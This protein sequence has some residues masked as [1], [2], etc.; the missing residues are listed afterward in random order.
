MLNNKFYYNLYKNISNHKAKICVIGL[1]YVGLK[2]LLI[3]KK[4]FLT[5]GYDNNKNKISKIKKNLSPLSHI[6]DSEIK[7]KN[8]SQSIITNLKKISNFNI[9]IICLPTPLKNKKPDLSF[10]I[11]FMKEASPFLKE[12]QLLILEST[13]YPG[14]TNEII[15]PFIKNK[16]LIVGKNFFL[17]YSPERENP[18]S[19]LKFQ[20]VTKI[21]SGVTKNCQNLTIN[22]YK[23]VTKTVDASSV[24][25]AEFAKLYEN[26]YRSVN[27]GLV[28]EMKMLA[29]KMNI[30]IYEIIRLAKTKPFGFK[31]FYPGPGIGGHCIPVDPYYLSWKAKN[32]NF[33]TKFIDLSGKINELT[34]D[35]VYKE[36]MKIIS[37]N[38][39]K[40]NLSVLVIG[41]AYKKNID[42]Y[43]ESASIKIIN[44]LI[45]NNIRIDYHDS[46]VPKIILDKKFT[47]KS[48]DIN[49]NNIKKYTCVILL[50]DHDNINY[51]LILNN[52][53]IIIDTR[54]KFK[55]IKRDNI[56]QL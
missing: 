26:I 46:F 39:S 56:Y 15:K 38:N 1:G 45:K 18:G 55:N 23:K 24:E 14:T 53:K 13:T 48:V 2:L 37:K 47:L 44:K 40:N 21:C 51:R 30:N 25:H 17:G 8:L 35:W 20:N 43:R 42:D 12:G 50:T 27:I 52:S 29:K 36:T 33:E 41:V 3:L 4:K 10:I 22:L 49:K 19:K 31:A 34:T 6:K 9:I 28:N 7:N 54:G 16:K 5:Y 11:N 32:I